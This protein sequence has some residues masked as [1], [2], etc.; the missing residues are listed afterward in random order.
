MCPL[1]LLMF[2][3]HLPKHYFMKMIERLR[4][5]NETGYLWTSIKYYTFWPLV[6][7]FFLM[8]TAQIILAILVIAR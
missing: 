2:R 4:R 3:F 5:M 8:E 7:L 6:V 1:M